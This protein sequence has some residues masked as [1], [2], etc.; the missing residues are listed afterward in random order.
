MFM[1]SSK[2]SGNSIHSFLV[3]CI[4]C[5]LCY[6]LGEDNWRVFIFCSQYIY[7]YIIT[8][9]VIVAVLCTWH[10]KFYIYLT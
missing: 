10:D 6:M 2:S 7:I 3:P 8:Y 1:T 4:H 5:L 9:F